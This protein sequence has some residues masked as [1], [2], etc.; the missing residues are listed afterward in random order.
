VS[1]E[2]VPAWSMSSSAFSTVQPLL[3]TIAMLF[4]FAMETYFGGHMWEW[5]SMRR[6]LDFPGWGTFEQE[7]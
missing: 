4:C 2:E 7:V 5:T 1:A 3:G 6:G